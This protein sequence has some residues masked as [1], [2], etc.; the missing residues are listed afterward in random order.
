MIAISRL[1]NNGLGVNRRGTNRLGNKSDNRLSISGLHIDSLHT[2]GLSN[3]WL[4]NDGLSSDGLSSDGI[5]SDGLS[6]DGISSDGLS[7]NRLSVSGLGIDR[8]GDSV[9]GNR[10]HHD[11]RR[12]CRAVTFDLGVV[13]ITSKLVGV[14]ILP[15]TG[16]SIT[17]SYSSRRRLPAPQTSLRIGQGR[18]SDLGRIPSALSH[19]LQ[20]IVREC[21]GG[22]HDA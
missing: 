11:G 17:R 13:G 10:S 7:I 18:I 12:L 8:L 4:S 1:S 16:I 5:R 9:F 19:L 2:S 22:I 3:D 6:S 21:V 14:G 15:L 20:D